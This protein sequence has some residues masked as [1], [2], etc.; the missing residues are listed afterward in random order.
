MNGQMGFDELP[1]LPEM[2]CAFP[3][4]H[5]AHDWVLGLATFRCPGMT[6]EQEA[7]LMA[8]VPERAF[9]GETYVPPR[10]GG[11]LRAQLIRVRSVMVD[12]GWHT[13]AELSAATG[14]PESSVSARLRDLR[15][16]KHGGH[17]VDREFVQKGLFRYRLILREDP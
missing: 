16:P 9:G 6:A 11:R 5:D 1:P 12:G 14:D 2:R 3:T 4:L 15:K 7:A 13:L 8:S 17:T 10:D